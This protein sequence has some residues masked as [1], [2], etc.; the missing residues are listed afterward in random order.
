MLVASAPSAPRAGKRHRPARRAE[1]PAEEPSG[2]LEVGCACGKSYRIPV[3]HLGKRFRCQA[4]GKALT[5]ERAADPLTLPLELV[6]ASDPDPIPVPRPSAA[7]RGRGR[8]RPR[9]AR[10]SVW[11]LGGLALVIGLGV[12]LA[13][14]VPRALSAAVRR[15]LASRATWSTYRPLDRSYSVELPGSPVSRQSRLETPGEAPITEHVAQ[16]LR[17][18]QVFSVTHFHLGSASD[19]LVSLEATEAALIESLGPTRG[20]VLDRR[21]VEIS[22]HRGRELV[23]TFRLDDGGSGKGLARQVVTPDGLIVQLLVGMA[24]T[25]WDEAMARRCLDSLRLGE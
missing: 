7:G 17:P 25:V 9:R 1:R 16:L 11:V 24:E 4:C 3:A 13:R 22:G 23:L 19:E 15:Q 12:A 5:V 21:E 18:D 8:S 10:W 2:K 14:Q 20:A 6:A